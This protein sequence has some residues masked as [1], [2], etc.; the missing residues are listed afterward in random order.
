[1][2]NTFLITR[3]ISIDAG[4]RVTYHGSKCRSL[5]GHRYRIVVEVVGVL[6]E[7]GE[8]EGMV[9]DFGFL[10]DLMM[11]EIDVFY[12][13]GLILW[14]QDPLVEVLV[15]ISQDQIDEYLELNHRYTTT[16]N[17]GKVILVENVPTAEN[18]ARLWFESL[19]AEVQ[20]LTQGRARLNS[21][22][23]WETPNCSAVYFHPEYATPF[24]SAEAVADYSDDEPF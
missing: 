15:D 24:E 18:L 22:Q 13:H 8:S 9:L 23:V 5:H 3:E 20:S 16:Q 11:R 19:V 14:R 10:K 4:H 1:M 7:S 2:A 21:V 12:D 17:C 6:V